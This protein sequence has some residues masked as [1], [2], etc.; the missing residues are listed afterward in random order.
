MTTIQDQSA[1]HKGIILA[2]GSGSRLYLVPMKT[3]TE[4]HRV[5]TETVK[6]RS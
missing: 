3:A 1:I 6:A 5:L 2:S 4:R